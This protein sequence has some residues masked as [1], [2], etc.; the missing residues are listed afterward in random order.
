MA[1]R[2]H[3]KRRKDPVDTDIINPDL[4]II[5]SSCPI[6]V[7]SQTKISNVIESFSPVRH[8]QFLRKL[9][10]GAIRCFGKHR[11]FYIAVTVCH[12]KLNKVIV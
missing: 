5:S 2:F 6:S 4:T 10:L 7:N 3:Y 1:R 12:L 8:Y 9:Y 11:V